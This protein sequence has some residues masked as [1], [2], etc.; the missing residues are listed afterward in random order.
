MSAKP[1]WPLRILIADDD[2]DTAN[3]LAA[4]MRDEGHDVKVVLRGDEVLEMERLLRPDVLIVDINMPGMSGYAIAR[5]L[6]EQRG[7]A[8]PLLIAISGVWTRTSGRLL[9]DVVGFDHY[10][11]KPCDPGEIVAITS[12][13]AQRGAP[14]PR[15]PEF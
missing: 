4:L 8:T 5:E 11:L 12:S 14:P 3:T 15:T 10:L 13:Y 2:R 6:R 9:G 7:V 1:R